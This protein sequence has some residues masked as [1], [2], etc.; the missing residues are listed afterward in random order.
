[1]K[2]YAPTEISSDRKTFLFESDD[3]V[4]SATKEESPVY[5]WV[6]SWS[7]TDGVPKTNIKF[8]V[9]ATAAQINSAATEA[10]END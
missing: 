5:G 6:M 9:Q 10:S 1:V 7:E 8:S 2:S 4:L 3:F